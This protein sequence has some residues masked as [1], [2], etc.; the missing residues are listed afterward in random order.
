[1][2]TASIFPFFRLPA[3]LRSD[4]L[5][6]LLVAPRGI[7]LHSRTTFSGMPAGALFTIMSILHVNVQMYQ[8]ASAILYGQNNFVLNGQSHRLP[9]HLTYP[10]GFL[11]EQGQDAR[12]RVQALS[13]YLTRFGGEFEDVLAPALSDMVLSGRLRTLKVFL[14]QPS[15]RHSTISISNIVDRQPFQALLQILADPDLRHVELSVWGVHWAVFCPFHS[16]SEVKIKGKTPVESV[17]ER[18]LATIQGF[19]D[20]IQLNWIEMVETL[21][22]GE[23]IL[24]VDSS[25][26]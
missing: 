13:L 14:G 6:R 2:A 12:R 17:D 15:S 21:G 26:I 8:E 9:G 11:S 20:W 23:R 25:D 10:G 24:K 4:I 16:T 22:K 1:M 7:V 5:T 19:S 3:E 18:G